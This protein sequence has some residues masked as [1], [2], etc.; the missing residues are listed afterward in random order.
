MSRFPGCRGFRPSRGDGAGRRRA[1]EEPLPGRASLTLY[2]AQLDK[3]HFYDAGL[4][5]VAPPRFIGSASGG[6]RA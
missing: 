3:R 6:F 4:K 1:P 2:L 5:F